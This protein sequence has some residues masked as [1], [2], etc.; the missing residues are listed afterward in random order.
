MAKARNELSAGN[1]GG[2]VTFS[3]VRLDLTVE[4]SVAGEKTPR[5][6]RFESGRYRTRDP[7]IISA[8]HRC[9]S[10]RRQFQEVA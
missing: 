6:V 4:I 3:S 7:V 5:R 2:E 10:Y 9:G 1:G 8:L